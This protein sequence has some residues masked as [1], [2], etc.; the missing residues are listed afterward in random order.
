MTDYEGWDFWDP[1][2]QELPP[3]GVGYN[4]P[5]ISICTTVMNRLHDLQKTLP[6]NMHHNR[7]YP[8]VE[9]VILDYN[10]SDYLGEYIR[11]MYMGDIER[12]RLVYARTEEPQYFSMAHSRNLAFKVA[13]GYI[14]NNVDADNF[15]GRHFVDTLARMACVQPQKAVFAKGKRM[16]HG[17]IG[18]YKK[19]FIELGGYDE[20]LKGYGA[21]DSNLMYRAM[22]SGYKLM[23]WNQLGKFSHRLKTDRRDKVLHME[24]KNWKETEEINKAITEKNLA[25]GRLI[26]N[27]GRPWGASRIVKNF[28]EELQLC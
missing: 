23:W 4:Q 21:D 7:E 22:A 15:I 13:S 9:F 1:E 10:S 6:L 16:M 3:M 18:F 8:N 27:V 20:D 25:E 11:R 2:I 5:K 17:R 24:N 14:V 26:A 19:E 12:G 28:K